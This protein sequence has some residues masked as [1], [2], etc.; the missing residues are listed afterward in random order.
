MTSENASIEIS[1]EGRARLA[2]LA[3]VILP[4]A[5]TMPAASDVGV[6]ADVLDRVLF[7]CPGLAQPLLRALE[8]DD[9]GNPEARLRWLR[10]HAPDLFST[11]TLVVVSAYYMSPLVRDRIGYDGQQARRIDVFELPGYLEDGSIERV[12]ARGPL[13]RPVD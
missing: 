7:A 10:Q 1:H 8:A 11:L 3:D 4:A 13:F 2:R 6:A 9:A 5:A 12:V